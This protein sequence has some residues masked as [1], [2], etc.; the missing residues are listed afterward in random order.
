AHVCGADGHVDRADLVLALNDEQV[1]VAL[2][3]LEEDALVRRRRDGVVG[4]ERTTSLELRDSGDLVA[5]REDAGLRFRAR[6][7]RVREVFRAL[8]LLHV[9]EREAR[10]ADVELADLGALA[11]ELAADDLSDQVERVIAQRER[12]AEADGVLHDLVA[13]CLFALADLFERL[14]DDLHE[15]DRVEAQVRSLAVRGLEL[16]LAVVDDAAALVDLVQV[17]EVGRPAAM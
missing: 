15:R 4:L 12:R 1:V 9:L 10:G 14:L 11:L 2:V 6:L 3:P 5:L 17:A 13:P 8:V 16:D 7:E